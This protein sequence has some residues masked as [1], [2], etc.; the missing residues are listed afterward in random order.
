MSE[1]VPEAGAERQVDE[2][3][4]RQ[5]EAVANGCHASG[6]EGSEPSTRR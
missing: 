4:Q 6:A 1:S 5:G 3:K 2:E